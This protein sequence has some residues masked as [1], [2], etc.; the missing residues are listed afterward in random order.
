[1][2]QETFNRRS[3]SFSDDFDTTLMYDDIEKI[4]EMEEEEE[5]DQNGKLG[6]AGMMAVIAGATLIAGSILSTIPPFAGW[7][8]MEF[9][10]EF[11]VPVIGY[12]A[13][14]YGM[15]KMINLAFRR[16]ELNFP[17][18]NVYRKSRPAPAPS[19]KDERQTYRTAA[20]TQRTQR[21]QRRM[22]QTR[23]RTT[24]QVFEQQ[25]E[26]K[27]ILRRSRTNRVFSGVA[28]GLAEYTGVSVTLIR[29]A[30]IFSLFVMGFF[31]IPV[32]IYLLLSIVLPANFDPFEEEDGFGGNGKKAPIE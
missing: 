25:Q 16:K 6:S 28:G 11:L 19:P 30:F 10:L 7:N 23:S 9:V 29:F 26:D 13:L 14:G 20:R 31:P 18:L 5:K 15:I 12:S 32:F 8:F 22:Y 24:A 1:M 4:R 17:T 2:S 21:T 3:S 27:K